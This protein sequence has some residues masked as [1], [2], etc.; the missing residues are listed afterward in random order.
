MAK[1][2][3]SNI[4]TSQTFQAW[5]DRT[6]EVIDILK[7]DTIT[8]S[9]LGD[10]TTGNATL[11]GSFTANTIIAFT[12]LRADTLSPKVG[13]SAIAITAP[14]SITATTQV[15]QTLLSTVGPRAE[16]SSGSVI[17][18]TGFDNAINNNFII[19]SGSGALKLVL[20]PSGDLSVA[21][22]FVGN[23]TGNVTGDISGNANT[24]TN[25]VY[26]TGNQTIDGTKT[27]ANAVVLNTQ[28]TTTA[29]AVRADRTIETGTGLTG[30]GNLTAN[31][32][33][34][35]TGQA[36]A[37]HNLSSSGIVT[38]TAT[39]TVTARAI[40]AGDGISVTN[41]DGISGNPVIT[42]DSSIVRTSRTI[43]TGT[44]L[45]GG[46]NLTANRTISIIEASITD[47]RNGSSGSVVMTPRRVSDVTLGLNQTWQGVSRAGD[48]WYQ[49]TTGKAIQVQFRT[50]TGGSYRMRIG[51][52]TSS[53]ITQVIG[54]G[55]SG[56]WNHAYNIIPNGYFWLVENIGGAAVILEAY[57]LR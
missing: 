24:V 26:T 14:V 47:A 21:G 39:N 8:A 19:D 23:L 13:S 29:Q 46:G 41:G 10:S 34:T 38:R 51:P 56:T 2:G 17:W 42:V 9:A 28:G 7:T 53:F 40:T 12:T 27:F 36:L 54:D 3:L 5:L 32:T 33:L 15:A 37:L 11:V 49:N 25:G 44:G 1:P 18:R 48:T 20:T 50:G 30:G 45:T 55:S 57:E 35:L 4:S 43:A 52:S 16:F 6:N 31:R 22:S